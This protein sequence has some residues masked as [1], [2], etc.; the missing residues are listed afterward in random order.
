MPAAAAAV[1]GHCLG[2]AVGYN[3]A[4]AAAAAATRGVAA[5]REAHRSGKLARLGGSR[6]DRAWVGWGILRRLDWD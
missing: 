6:A 1:V 3:E 2:R 5:Q 4:A